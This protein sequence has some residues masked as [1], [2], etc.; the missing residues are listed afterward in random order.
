M[1][2]KI[3]HTFLQQ[4]LEKYHYTSQ[5][6]ELLGR[7]ASDMR[8]CI[9]DQERFAVV[10]GDSWADVVVTLGEGLDFL[11]EKY[12][13]QEE[14]MKQ[15]MLESISAE[16]LMQEY[17]E[18]NRIIESQ[19]GLHV[20]GLHFWGS[21]EEYPLEKTPQILQQF[22]TIRVK[23]TQDYC[24]LP[25]KSVLYRCELSKAAKTD[26]RCSNVCRN[27]PQQGDCYRL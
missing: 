9:K 8:S 24:L 10:L 13:R 25:S 14:L 27:C 12:T 2:G 3:T 5:D 15:W 1:C 22:S 11:Q 21:E 23:T 20:A 7:V 18:I 17:P 4:V 19:T 6:M 26:L 16:L